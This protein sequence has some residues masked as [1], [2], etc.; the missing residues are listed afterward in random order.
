MNQSRRGHRHQELVKLGEVARMVD[1]IKRVKSEN[2]EGPRFD[3]NLQ[4]HFWPATE[5]FTNPS[6]LNG[7]RGHR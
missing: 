3:L 4:H 7:V 6:A 5:R 1:G 2:K